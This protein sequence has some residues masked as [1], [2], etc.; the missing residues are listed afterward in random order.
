MNNGAGQRLM[1]DNAA[2]Q[3]KLPLIIREFNANNNYNQSGGIQPQ[4]QTFVNYQQHQGARQIANGPLRDLDN[5]HVNEFVVSEQIV[6][7]QNKS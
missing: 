5:L 2:P 3:L 4:Q 1:C 7:T 6:S